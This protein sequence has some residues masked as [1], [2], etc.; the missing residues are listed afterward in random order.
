MSIPSISALSLSLNILY[1]GHIL[2][3]RFCGWVTV[4]ILSLGFLPGYRKLSLQ[5]PYYTLI[6]VLARIVPIDTLGPTPISGLWHVLRMPA[7]PP[8]SLVFLLLSLHLIHT[9]LSCSSYLVPSLNSTLISISSSETDSI[10]LP[11]NFLVIW[12][13]CVW[14]V[15]WLF[16]TLWLI[17]A[18]ESILCM[19]SWV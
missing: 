7:F 11:W 2:G 5:D 19:S 8:I 4:L 10:T 12:L 14:I 18:Y 9:P 3:W 16:C 1:P 13:L 15:A 17:S 6:E